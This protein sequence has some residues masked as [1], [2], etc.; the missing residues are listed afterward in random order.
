MNAKPLYATISIGLS[1]NIS[2]E[3]IE[4]IYKGAVNIAKQYGIAIIGGDTGIL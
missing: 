2:V 3:M 4:Q 1:N